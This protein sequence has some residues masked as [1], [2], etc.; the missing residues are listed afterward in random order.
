MTAPPE[1][2][3]DAAAASLLAR[4]EQARARARA[5]L[6]ATLVVEAGAGTGKTTLMVERILH[7]LRSGAATIP[8]IVAITFTEKAAAELR[9]RLRAKLDTAARVA[10]AD[11]RTRLRAA[12]DRFDQAQIS[13]IHAFAQG[14]LRERPLEVGL[15][16]EF[17][18]MDDLT[19][20]LEFER[21]WEEWLDAELSGAP[22]AARRALNLGM[23]IEH[24]QQMALWLHQERDLLSEQTAAVPPPVATFPAGALPILQELEQ[25]LSRCRSE[26]DAGARQI[27]G[28]LRWR[29]IALRA[30][31][32]A[33][34]RLLAH[35][36]PFKPKG[37]QRNWEGSAGARQK[38]LCTDLN[39]QLQEAR[40][41]LGQSA[42]VAVMGWLA[43]FVRWYEA[44][45]REEGKA[46]FQD[47]LVWA[48]GLLRDHPAVR[49]TFQ[50]R[51]RYLLVDEVQD[52]DPLQAEIVAFLAEDGAH[53]RRWQQA[54]PAPGRLF[55]VGDPKQAI[56]RFRR[57]DLSVY[58]A[59]HGLVTAAGGESLAI[60]QNFRS[61]PPLI[62][63]VN[64]L[65]SQLMGPGDPPYQAAYD[66]LEPAIAAD[67][68]WPHPR[69]IALH[70]PADTGSGRP[71]DARTRRRLEAGA[72]ARLLRRAVEEQHWPV[73]ERGTGGTRPLR[74]GDVA[75][76]FGAMTDVDLFEDA[77]REAGVPYRM[78]GGRLFYDRQEVRD[79]TNALTAVDDPTDGI[80]LTATLLSAPFGFTQEELFLYVDSGGRLDY[81]TQPDAEWPHLRAAFAL[82][83]DLHDRRNV[84]PPAQVVER[85]I[86]GARMAELALLADGGE[87]AA[88]NLFKVMEQAR[89]FG[90]AGRPFRAFVRWLAGA[91]ARTARESDVAISEEGADAVRLMTMHAAKGLEFPVVVLANTRARSRPEPCVVDR[92]TGIIDLRA[93]D[94][95]TIFRTPGYDDASARDLRH[96]EAER[97]RLLYVACTRAADHLVIPV[98]PGSVAELG[99]AVA[100][101]DV[102]DLDAADLWREPAEV[103]AMRLTIT[104]G[105]ESAQALAERQAWQA[106]RAARWGGAVAA[107]DQPDATGP[108]RAVRDALDQLAGELD[109]ADAVTSAAADAAE[110]EAMAPQTSAVAAL[111]RACLDTPPLRAAARDPRAL[112]NRP[113][114]HDRI[115]L[116]YATSGGYALVCYRLPDEP[117]DEPAARLLAATISERLGRPVTEIWLLFL[118]TAEAERIA[119]R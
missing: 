2:L 34:E 31:P 47:L 63:W 21:R 81:L 54:Q 6:A 112:W 103:P 107:A 87:Q 82:L 61:A 119:E 59:L 68:Q 60:T 80:A 69:V 114:G 4:D 71:P 118:A 17:S 92:V 55:I 89:A 117:R 11:E 13:T 20:T 41:A 7:T 66:P 45:R 96:A 108:A 24:L 104:T 35:L 30:S 91:R 113:L 99:L 42:T 58:F 73:R 93:G 16:P 85:L 106:A 36:E 33:L 111:L 79:L 43:G 84:D 25:L 44:V 62:G 116:L 64:R 12:L 8:A 115:D 50:R 9:A 39:H 27:R 3:G 46:E 76:L 67:P 77:L 48:R 56:Y 14:L 100:S 28:L 23:R 109:G 78:E 10:V 51:F 101:G 22:A 29:D 38:E 26:Q 95:S 98:H 97:R 5:D 32:P 88:G 94:E 57:A 90:G 52:T 83:R 49:A 53:A 19:A 110:N 70:L 105:P 65:F 18:V 37:N 40:Q 72:V 15:D 1:G 74:Y 86:A 102:L 75:L